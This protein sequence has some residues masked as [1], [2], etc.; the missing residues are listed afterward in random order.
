MEGLSLMNKQLDIEA[1][2]VTAQELAERCHTAS[3]KGGWWNDPA[4]GAPL[5]VDVP[6][7][8]VLV[9]SELSE[10]LEGDRKDLM[11]SHLPHRKSIEVELA[12]AVIRIFDLAGAL[13]LDIV[14]AMLE[15]MA[16]NA[17]RSDHK[18]ENRTKSNGKKY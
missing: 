3:V 9:H 2:F 14:L 10:A 13:K 4:T 5:P 16:Y 18:A 6:L 12:D 7:K 11:D 17:A 15:K 1:N 8:L